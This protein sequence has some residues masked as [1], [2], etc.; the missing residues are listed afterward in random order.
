MLATHTASHLNAGL[1][2]C[3][4]CQPSDVETCTH[5]FHFCYFLVPAQECQVRDTQSLWPQQLTSPDIAEGVPH[6]TE[7]AP[8]TAEGVPHTA[9]GAPHTAEGALSTQVLKREHQT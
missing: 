1:S 5:H 9:E 7:G 3:R 8:H 4:G 6:T 2:L